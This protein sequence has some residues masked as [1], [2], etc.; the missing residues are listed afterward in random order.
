MISKVHSIEMKPEV[1]TFELQDL[2][3]KKK[4]SQD[5]FSYKLSKK[6][7]HLFEKPSDS[8]KPGEEKKEPE[9]VS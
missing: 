3:E 6:V 9:E 5:Q 8:S 2:E 1:N 7:K 4:M